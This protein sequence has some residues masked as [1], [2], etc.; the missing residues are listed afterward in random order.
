M[1][2]TLD[3]RKVIVAGVFV[4]LANPWL[5]AQDTIPLRQ[6]RP[7]LQ[8]GVLPEATIREVQF[9]SLRIGWLLGDGKLWITKDGGA[10]WGL[11]ALPTEGLVSEVAGIRFDVRPRFFSL[12][13][14]LNGWIQ[15]GT[16]IIRTVDGG[17]TW[18]VQGEIPVKDPTV[19]GFSSLSLVGNGMTGWAAGVD[20]ETPKSDIT[21]GPGRFPISIYRTVDGG[22]HWTSEDLRASVDSN[23]VL[24][25][26]LSEQRAV[27]ATPAGLFYTVT[28]KEGWTRA[29][30]R[31]KDPSEPIQPG[32][33]GG[34]FFA[35]GEHGWIGFEEGAILETSDSGRSWRVVAGPGEV[36]DAPSGVGQF[37]KIYFN[38]TEGWVL[39]AD[40][41]VHETTDGGVSWHIVM[42][43]EFIHDI[44]CR[45]LP[46]ERFGCWALGTARIWRLNP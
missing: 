1:L 20:L 46:S 5:A 30:V 28:G 35:G 11:A 15:W 23:D 18:A 33:A 3:R 41:A 24:I 38:G 25:Y 32:K 8:V 37:G 21:S 19:W 7:L 27:A 17:D 44:Y 39:G 43:E 42:A 13:D 34:F 9:A 14:E 6:A 45:Q 2:T 4:G 36:W 22:V 16:K 12:R 29:V 40:G 31:Q 26:G 10:H